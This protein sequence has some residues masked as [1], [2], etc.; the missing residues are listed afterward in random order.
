[1]NQPVCFGTL[2]A[3]MATRAIL[4]LAV[5]SFPTATS[6]CCQAWSEQRREH[7]CAQHSKLLLTLG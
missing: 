6:G 4:G 3:S 2:M 7:H 1:M 5:L